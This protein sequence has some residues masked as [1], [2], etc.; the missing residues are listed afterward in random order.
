MH[1][2][3]TSKLGYLSFK[4]R[5]D[6]PLKKT[7]AKIL[8]STKKYAISYAIDMVLVTKPFLL[9]SNNHKNGMI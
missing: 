3:P 6:L 9:F 1:L 5:A 8:A 2:S 4:I 7:C